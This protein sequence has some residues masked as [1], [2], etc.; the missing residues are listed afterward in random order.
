MG[1]KHYPVEGAKG[2]TPNWMQESKME[3]EHLKIINSL[4]LWCSLNIY[5]IYACT[6]LYAGIC[7]VLNNTHKVPYH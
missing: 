3:G 4:Q 6:P 2:Q 7:N 1:I 5:I